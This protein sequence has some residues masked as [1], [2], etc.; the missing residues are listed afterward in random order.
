MRLLFFTDTHIRGNTP[1]SR[2]D[3]ILNTLFQKIEEIIDIAQQWQVDYILHGGDI[4]DRPDISP[5]IVRDVMKLFKR[6][7][8]PIY[9]VAGNHDLYGHNPQTLHRTMVGLLDAAGIIKMLDGQHKLLQSGNIKVQLSGISYSYDIDSSNSFKRYYTIKKNIDADFSIHVVHG[10][11]LDKKFIEG[12]PYTLLD[13]ICHTEADITLSGHYHTG[14]GIKKI[15]DKYFVNPGSILRISN[16]ISELNRKPAVVLIE[17]VK[18]QPPSIQL[19]NLKIAKDGEL[20]LDRSVLERDSMQKERLDYIFREI[21][22]ATKFNSLNLDT[23][24]NGIIADQNIASDV[25]KEAL[26]RISDIR[27]ILEE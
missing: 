17:L 25:K 13:D 24:I 4:F 20:V 12:I 11:L 9:A 26:K 7:N 23:I 2:K 14:F 10:M 15:F 22:S 5:S 3:N 27:V 19:I 18:G 21:R 8:R 6:F 16:N 1:R